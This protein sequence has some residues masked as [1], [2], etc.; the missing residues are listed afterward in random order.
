M[1]LIYERHTFINVNEKVK[2]GNIVGNLFHWQLPT[3]QN[4]ERGDR[5]A[6]KRYMIRQYCIDQSSDPSELL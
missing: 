1:T 3:C 4:S 6:P 2:L 5:T